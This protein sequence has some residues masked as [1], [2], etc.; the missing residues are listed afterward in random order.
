MKPR[1][2]LT[3]GLY[4]AP[5]K[6]YY[7][8]DMEQWTTTLTHM[9]FS[10]AAHKRS[11]WSSIERRKDPPRCTILNF[12]SMVLRK[13]PTPSWGEGGRKDKFKQCG[14][15]CLPAWSWSK[16]KFIHLNL[17]LPDSF[18]HYLIDS[19]KGQNQCLVWQKPVPNYSTYPWKVRSSR[20]FFKA[21]AK[22]SW[23]I[24]RTRLLSLLCH[25]SI[26]FY[27]KW[28]LHQLWLHEIKIMRHI[29][30]CLI[31]DYIIEEVVSQIKT[32]AKQH[33]K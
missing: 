19:E 25:K 3:C 32:S 22:N 6:A 23:F 27:I 33:M 21:T 4:R 13:K 8:G 24:S 1:R 30:H 15:K 7:H 14:I 18:M 9:N 20:G 17:L 2:T 16:K 31:N 26:M 10:P 29:V 11:L 5:G 28:S 12:P